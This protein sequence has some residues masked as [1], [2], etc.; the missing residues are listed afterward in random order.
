[1]SKNEQRNSARGRSTGGRLP[2][3]WALIVAVVLLPAV[4]LGFIAWRSHRETLDEARS[5]VERTARVL[6]EHALKVFET[7]RLV[8][9]VVDDRLRFTDLTKPGDAAALHALLAQLQTEL[10]QV[11]AITVIGPDGHMLASGRTFPNDP[12]VSFADRDYFIALKAHGQ[13]MPYVSRAYLGRQTGKQIF[14]LAS[15]IG[16]GSDDT[17]RGVVAVS[18]NRSYFEDFYQTVEPTYDHRVILVRD[19]GVILASE[20]PLPFAALTPPSPLM[21]HIARSPNGF[22]FGGSRIDH[23]ERMF[24]YR[25]IGTYPVFVRF[26]ISKQNALAAWRHALISYGIVAGLVTLALAAVAR[27]A[28][29]QTRR[30]RL[31]HQLWEETATQLRVQAIERE[32][33]E[34]QLRQSQKMEAVGRLTGGVAHD[35]NNLLTA[36]IGSLDLIR[37]RPEGLDPRHAA[38]IDNASEGA[39]RAAA[40]VARLLAF[41]RQQP[42][43]PVQVDVN[44]LVAGMSELLRRTL[45]ETIAV[46][47]VLAGGLWPTLVDANQLESVVLNL[48]VNARDAMAA[49]GGGRLTIE[50]A[51]AHLDETYAREHSEVVAGHYVM[52]AVSDTGCGMPPEI[53]AQAFEPFFTTKPVGQGTGLGLSQVYG[54]VKQSGG[55]VA[56]YS[57]VDQGTT[58]RIYLP[59]AT[60]AKATQTSATPASAIRTS[61]TRPLVASPAPGNVPAPIGRGECVLVVEDEAM[62][63]RLSVAAL[64]D[65]GFRVIEAA[66]GAQGLEHARANADIRLLFTDVV[67][68]G[69]MNGRA[70]ADAVLALRPQMPVLFTTG[71]TRNA[72]IHHGRL[73]DGVHVIGKPF[74]SA[75]LI[76]KVQELLGASAVA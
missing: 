75:E 19:D 27:V 55:H 7:H 15:R 54:F 30:E 26:G 66:D 4:L 9:Q 32:A 76:A 39:E 1:M 13:T 10:P 33:I 67:L 2:P 65:A 49:A 41:S 69:T 52:L 22:Y 16:R 8:L 17:F 51:N 63:R 68:G 23:V 24:A 70:L 31:A 25:R 59:R 5:R 37:R 28:V 42:L 57:E 64:E 45:G 21:D 43:K 44:R 53:I 18:V 58:F 50:T 72:I 29:L 36:V 60:P 40:L 3:D 73:D 20:T 34:A 38:L 47:T 11:S 74:T 14:N 46:E 71:Y 35:F 61:A 62:V 48:A 12:S 6:E 56:I